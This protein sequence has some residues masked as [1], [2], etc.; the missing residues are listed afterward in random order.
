MAGETTRLQAADF[1]IPFGHSGHQIG[2]LVAPLAE[3]TCDLAI[4]LWRESP[5][6]GIMHGEQRCPRGA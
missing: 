2:D 6:G 5:C 1:G 3:F 4:K